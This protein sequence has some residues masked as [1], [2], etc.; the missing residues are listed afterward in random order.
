M[1]SITL[2]GSAYDREVAKNAEILLQNRF[3]ENNP[4][5]NTD[6]VSLISRPG[7]NKFAT[8]GE[9]P[10]R[11]IYPAVGSFNNDCFVVSSNNLFR[12]DSRTG[13]ATDLGV[14]SDDPIGDVTMAITAPIG[15]TPEYLFLTEGQV[16][17]FYTDNGHARA[18][19]QASGA[20]SNGETM[21][22]NGVHYQ[23]T[24]GSVDAGTP[25][26]SSGSP[27]LVALGG[28]T[29][30]TIANL[31]N[32]VGAKGEA[33]VDYTTNLTAHTTVEP[34]SYGPA[35]AFFQAIDPGTVGNGYAS[36]ET[37]ANASFGGAT[38]TGGGT[39]QLA[40][41]TL[42]ND[43]G[44]ISLTYINSYIIVIPVQTEALESIGKF[45]WIRPGE[46]TIDPLSFANAERSP[47]KLHQV[48]TYNNMFWLFGEQTVEPWLVTGQ[49]N[50]DVER[51]QGILF[52]RG[53]WEGTA[54][55]VK[56][57]MIVCD[58]DGG[59]FSIS[60]GIRRISRPDIEERIRT[61]FE[62]QE[63]LSIL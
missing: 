63:R 35:D 61:A 42:P 44:A 5:L 32:A 37:M 47:D 19:L 60:S 54:V 17:W 30:A 3:A 38:F 11:K 23:L 12:V 46:V 14:I 49:L 62:R 52:D 56:D 31:F 10:I 51:F 39:D 26:G 53:S 55:K 8:V 48:L 58:E 1:V 34:L 2:G 4:T 20:F 36:T 27:W 59:V 29:A 7:M 41:V 16:L 22:L 43:E 40:Q 45:Y 15:T 28:D 6:P 33:G 50:D 21:E 18:Q 57:Q 9:G 25:D 13:A 24:S